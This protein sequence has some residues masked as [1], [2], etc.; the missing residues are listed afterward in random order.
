MI[1]YKN[2]NRKEEKM[3]VKK[4][5]L[6][7]NLFRLISISIIFLIVGLYIGRKFCI[8]RRHKY[9][10]EMSDNNNLSELEIKENKKENKLIDI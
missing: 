3:R 9:A 1:F 8:L 2:S 10:N 5:I 6:T 7:S 4:N